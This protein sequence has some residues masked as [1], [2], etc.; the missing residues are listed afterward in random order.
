MKKNQ[1]NSS[2]ICLLAVSFFS[3][4]G[5]NMVAPVFVEYLTEL[6]FALSVAGVLSGLFAF[7]SMGTRP[8]SGILTDRIRHKQL[9]VGAQVVMAL[10]MLIYSLWPYPVIL[11][12]FRTLHGIAFA[13]S[14]TVSLVLASEYTPPEKMAE[15]ISYFSTAQIIAMLL[16]PGLGITL[17][18]AA[19]A[20]T[21]MLS[22]AATAIPAVL[23]ACFLKGVPVG[24]DFTQK[25]TASKSVKLTDFIEVSAIGLSLMNASLTLMVGLGSTFL[26]SF[27]AER[28]IAGVSLHFTVNAAAL[29]IFRVVA[30]RYI[31]RARL[32]QILI[33][34]FLTGILSLFCIVWSHSLSL[35]LLSAILKA[36][37]YGLGQPALQTEA[38]R[39]AGEA[40]RGAAS[41]TVYIGGDMGQ[42]FSG[43]LGGVIAGAFSYTTLFAAAILPLALSLTGVIC[44]RTPSPPHT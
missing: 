23:L 7:A 5:Y 31:G 15:G 4:L 8:L 43:I 44:R 42:A 18:E 3:W 12:V 35:L 17:A 16:G 26:V 38:L 39:R 25:Q 27:A 9:L 24:N 21:C 40:R 29:L 22:S 20:Y 34:S 14:S 32:S 2:Y 30:A 6:G 19:G 1:W 37:S 11:W 33:P 36:I 10:S 28:G 41:G 13:V